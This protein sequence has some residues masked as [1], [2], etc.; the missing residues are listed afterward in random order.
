MKYK[1]YFVFGSKASLI[2]YIIF[3]LYYIFCWYN[4]RI[5]HDGRENQQWNKEQYYACEKYLSIDDDFEKEEFISKYDYLVFSN[6]NCQKITS[7]GTLP[8]SAFNIFE[9]FLEEDNFIFPF[10]IPIIVLSPFLYLISREIKNKV[11]KNY[12][13]RDDYKKYISHIFKVAYKNIFIIPM[14]VI[15]TFI[16]SYFL[17]G[18][19]MNTSADFGLNFILPN[20]SFIDNSIFPILY[21]VTLFLGMGLYINVGLIIL[22]KNKSFL[23]SVLE[24]EL[25]IFLIW[26]FSY[27]VFG[28]IFNVFGIN[29]N[30]FN[31][32]SIYNW[33]A[34]DNMYIYFGIN[35]FMFLITLIVVIIS[36]KN[37]EKL[38]MICEK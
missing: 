14:I 20:L 37:K 19:N 18:K 11:V 38:I 21:I 10:F 28:N 9:E 34:V 27:I 35:L 4:V 12:C 8:N 26:C 30:N 1:K 25:V 5:L 22:T 17:S 31:L 23:V 32:L 13:L 7:Y 6:D 3:I 2:M 15:L 33:A 16:I 29:S 24:S 36:Y